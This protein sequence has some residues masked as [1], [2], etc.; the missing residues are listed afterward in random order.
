[1]QLPAD[2]EQSYQYPISFNQNSSPASVF[3]QH[4]ATVSSDFFL[5]PFPVF[6][7]SSV[8]L[9]SCLSF[10][11]NL[12]S[13]FLLLSHFVQSFIL[14]F[15]PPVMDI[16]IGLIFSDYSFW[17]FLPFAASIIPFIHLP[18]EFIAPSSSSSL[19]PLLI[20]FFFHLPL[21]DSCV[22]DFVSIEFTAFIKTTH[23][24]KCLEASLIELPVKFEKCV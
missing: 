2:W 21:V 19:Q 9:N 3:C 15:L 1:M 20:D 10:V 23:S 22:L 16:F 4:W 17:A 13:L 6:L 7:S 5:A 8:F 18:P 12:T 24:I 14:Y 11:S